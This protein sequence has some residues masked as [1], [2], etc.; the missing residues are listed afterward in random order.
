MA[1]NC[2]IS[3]NFLLEL[4]SLKEDETFYSEVRL[5]LLEIVAMSDADLSSSV[6]MWN[7][8][9]PGYNILNDE[10]GRNY[11]YEEIDSI[12]ST[13]ENEST[14]RLKED[15]YTSR[16]ELE[17]FGGRDIDLAEYIDEIE[18]VLEYRKMKN[19]E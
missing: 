4:N 9:N 13:Y 5:K 17:D 14:E 7:Y 12:L 19:I 16:T 8:E 1:Y 15:L 10:L 6:E 18:L 11:E 2:D 3:V